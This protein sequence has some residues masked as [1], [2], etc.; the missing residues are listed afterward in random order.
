[1][2]N[3]FSSAI[4]WLSR[5][6]LSAKSG[7]PDGSKVATCRACGQQKPAA[8][9]SEIPFHGYFCNDDEAVKYWNENYELKSTAEADQ[10]Q[11]SAAADDARFSQSS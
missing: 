9:M 3:R 6:I 7:L 5:P 10:V 11:S 8:E 2:K 4:A 1:M